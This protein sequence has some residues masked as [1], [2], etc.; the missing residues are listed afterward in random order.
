MWY[1]EMFCEEQKYNPISFSCLKVGYTYLMTN[2]MFT[3]KEIELC[4]KLKILKFNQAF[5]CIKTVLIITMK[6]LTVISI[7]SSFFYHILM[8]WSF[9]S[10]INFS[11][12]YGRTNPSLLAN[13]H[14]SFTILLGSSPISNS[15]FSSRFSF[16]PTF[17]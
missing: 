17:W 3:V 2:E 12:I 1:L 16:Y 14:L 4:Y 6:Y 13:V 15:V 9:L 8:Q 7:W 5:I 11:P 10:I